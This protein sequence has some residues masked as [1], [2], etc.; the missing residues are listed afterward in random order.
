MNIKPKKRRMA[1]ALS[2]SLLAAASLVSLQ[3]GTFSNNF[4]TDPGAA[5]TL[6]NAAVWVDAGGGAGY[7]SLTENVG[8]KNGLLIIPD[9]DNAELVGGFTATFKLQIGPGSG[10]AADG[11]SF[12]WA[13]DLP[14]AATS[15]SEEGGGTGLTVSFDT[16]VNADVGET[17]PTIYIK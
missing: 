17:S 14:G 1:G 5:V 6:D 9:F 16:Y 4:N 2:A 11:F 3:A 12:N 15:V 7:I 10:N 13:A 8:S